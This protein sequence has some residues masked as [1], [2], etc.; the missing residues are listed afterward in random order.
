MKLTVLGP[1][2]WGLTIAWLLNN[3]FDEICVW[4]R[5]QDLSDELKDYKRATKPLTVQLDKKVEITD[6]LQK[7]V[8]GA[9]IIFLVVATSGIRPVCQQL[10]KIGLKDN[11]ILFTNVSP[12]K[13]EIYESEPNY[14]FHLV[15]LKEDRFCN[16]LF[17]FC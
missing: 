15:T 8:D 6:D 3:N 5:S 17:N 2:C 9:E 1:G 10:K 7:A 14:F 4:G 12:D 16:L 13:I 11:Q